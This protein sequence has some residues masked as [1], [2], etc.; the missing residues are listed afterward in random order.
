MAGTIYSLV[1]EQRLQDVL[2]TLQAFTGISIQLIDHDGTLLQSY[3]DETRYCSLLKKNVF[4]HGECFT[5]HMKAGERAQKIGEAYIFSCHANLSHIAFPLINQ[6]KLLGSV[7]VGPFLMGEPDSTVISGLADKYQLSPALSL[8]LYDELSGVPVI[9]PDRAG[10]LQKLVSYL[11]SSL[12]P[13]QRAELMQAQEKAYQQ[14]KINETIQVYKEQKLQPSLI[15]F[16][17]KEKELLAK[18]RAG[19]IQEVKG[20]LNELI[21]FVLFSE[22]GKLET[23]RTRAIE[24]TT[25]LSRVAMDGGANTDSIYQLNSQFLSL[26]Y[27]ER[28]LDDLCMLLQDVAESFTSAM[29]YEKDKGNL[30]IRKAL[31]FIAENYYEHL[32]L[33][34]VADAVQLSPGYF[35]A[36]FR[37]VVGMNF[38]EHL[39]AVRVEES[40]RLLLS[41]DYSLGDIAVS[42]GFPDQSYYCKMFKRMMGISPGK[43]RARP[44][45]SGEK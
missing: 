11:L 5:L 7:V 29:F 25:L 10:Q 19:S 26:I 37:Q 3:G 39:C 43:F 38:R 30:Y 34:D 12:I 27:Q 14:A 13:S 18:V 22:G 6:Q 33:S 21:G 42:V 32:E 23:M 4:T 16:H 1:P 44:T 45:T 40:K 9:S 15:F 41:T 28:D 8:D 24:L 2:Q 36:L 17:E 35:S 31:R 20:L